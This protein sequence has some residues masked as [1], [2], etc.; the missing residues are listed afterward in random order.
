MTV[1]PITSFPQ[2]LDTINSDQ[3][4]FIDFWAEWCGPCKAI[5][6]LYEGLSSDYGAVAKFYSVDID[7]YDDITQELRVTSVPTFI[8]FKN[9]NPLG[10]IVGANRGLLSV[11][12]SLTDVVTLHV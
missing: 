8:A 3:V 6:P 10:T 11:R 4:V 12:L 1:T 9:G 2:F 7:K 5:K